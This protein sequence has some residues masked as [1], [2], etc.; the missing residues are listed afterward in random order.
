MKFKFHFKNITNPKFW[1]GLFL[2]ILRLAVTTYL[3]MAFFV[4]LIII[5]SATIFN[6]LKRVPLLGFVIMKIEGFI[7]TNKLDRI[8]M[9][10]L[11][12]LESSRQ[13][14]VSRTYIIGLA[15]R[16]LLSKKTRTFITIL[17]MAVGV[18]IIVFLLSLGYGIERLVVGKVASLDELRIIDVTVGDNTALH[19]NNSI[20]EKITNLP[21]AQKVAPLIS[22]VGKVAFNQA[23]TDMIVYAASNDFINL[24]KIKLVKGTLFTAGED[25]N[26]SGAAARVKGA[27]DSL[28]P[29]REGTP[30]EQALIN[31]NVF[32]DAV[33]EV[34]KTCSINSEILGYLDRY[35]GGFQGQKYWGGT[36][37]PH[38]Q[39]GRVGYDK[40]SGKELGVWVKASI[41][42]YNKLPDGALQP[43]L[44][45]AG[46]QI[47]ADGCVEMPKLQIF[48]SP[49]FGTVLGVS[50]S[51]A[52]ES[53]ALSNGSQATDSAMYREVTTTPNSGGLEVVE[54]TASSSAKRA[55]QTLNFEHGPSSEAVVSSA[56]LNLLSIRPDKALGTTFRVSFVI[57]QSL[58]P[59]INGKAITKEAEYK[60][61]GV[62]DDVSATYFYVPIIDMKNLG[63]T[64]YSQLKVVVADKDSVSPARKGIET[65]GLRTASTNDT[66]SQI[67]DLFANLRIL[68][69][70]LG[71]VALAVASLGMFNTLTVSLLE[72]TR[73]IGGMKVMGMVSSEVQDLFLAEAMIMGLSGG[74]VGII[75]GF[76]VGNFLSFFISFYSIAAGQGYL[77]LTYIP[78][79][80]VAF[81]IVSSFIVGLFT[82]FYPAQRAKKISALNAL[83]YE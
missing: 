76:L 15:I 45:T 22:T 75:L 21:K 64:N 12:F 31:F 42:L 83:R 79:F 30:F 70:L 48:D 24:A 66:V 81:I 4:V 65:L 47:W 67:E 5:F 34:W 41:P 3:F 80:L 32:P 7:W 26:S 39:N 73:E 78:G 82:G 8:Y 50:T 33:V 53:A 62:T 43:T 63:I 52:S 13:T 19:L 27:T 69:G 58:K 54:L 38:N 9:K 17:G 11:R 28:M 14:E 59:E 16:N 51:V 49:D 46:Q 55:T 10:I 18:G 6:A 74:I 60:V 44:N 61:I 57:N 2:S 37:S 72:R 20:I 25:K 1:V 36:Y 40:N 77:N 23:N 29:A 56:M 35:E 71:M 68:L